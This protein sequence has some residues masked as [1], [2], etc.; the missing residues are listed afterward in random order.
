ML[1][2]LWRHIQND[3][4]GR[5]VVIRNPSRCLSCSLQDPYTDIE[6]TRDRHVAPE[7]RLWNVEGSDILLAYDHPYFPTT[8]ERIE[9]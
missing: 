4:R 8:S 2:M 1:S 5:V 7:D 6:Q 9:P 3:S